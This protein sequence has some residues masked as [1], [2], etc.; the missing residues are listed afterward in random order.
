[1]TR[2][3]IKDAV[4]KAVNASNFQVDFIDNDDDGSLIIKVSRPTYPG[5][6]K[7]VKGVVKDEI[8]I[9]KFKEVLAETLN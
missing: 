3:A 2:Q 1:M 4:V 8:D 9:G 5:Y 7:T 6:Q